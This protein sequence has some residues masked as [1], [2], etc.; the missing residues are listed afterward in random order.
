MTVPHQEEARLGRQILHELR[1][2]FDCHPRT[3]GEHSQYQSAMDGHHSCVQCGFE[4]RLEECKGRHCWKAAELLFE[5]E[6]VV[7]MMPV[8]SNREP[9]RSSKVPTDSRVTR[10]F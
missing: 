10:I 6:L 1:H 8:V 7:C 9:N 4:I 3:M 5:V 2:L